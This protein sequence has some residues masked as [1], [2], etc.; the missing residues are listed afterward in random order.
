MPSREVA[1]HRR[2]AT[3]SGVEDNGHDS[4]HG[5]TDAIDPKLLS[6]QDSSCNARQHNFAHRFQ[7][8]YSTASRQILNMVGVLVSLSA[9]DGS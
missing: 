4:G 1:G 8:V 7:G 3:M 9:R 6:H 2:E 5:E